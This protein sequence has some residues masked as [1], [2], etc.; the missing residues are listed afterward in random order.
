MEKADSDE[1]LEQQTIKRYMEE[2]EAWRGENNCGVRIGKP[3]K[4]LPLVARPI[5]S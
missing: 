2:R 4:V 5:R 3:K 1:Q